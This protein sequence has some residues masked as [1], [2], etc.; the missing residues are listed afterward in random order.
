[1]GDGE[2]SETARDKL[3]HELDIFHTDLRNTAKYWN[4][5]LEEYNE[6]MQKSIN[7]TPTYYRAYEFKNLHEQIKN[8]CMNQVCV[9]F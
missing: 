5:S 4:K 8:R 2:I 1:M 6:S 9:P 7:A 3:E